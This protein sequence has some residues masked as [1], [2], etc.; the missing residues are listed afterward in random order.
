MP[1]VNK[2]ILIWA[3][4]S[5][6]HHTN[7]PVDVFRGYAIADEIAPLRGRVGAPLPVNA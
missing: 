5:A 7:I 1:V 6:G 4:N 3:R 2:D